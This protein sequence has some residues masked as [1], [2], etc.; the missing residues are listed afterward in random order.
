MLQRI[1][2]RHRSERTSVLGSL[3][4]KGSDKMQW[5][6]LTWL[7]ICTRYFYHHCPQKGWLDSLKWIF[8][9]PITWFYH[10][11]KLLKMISSKFFV[12]GIEFCIW[13]KIYF[14]LEKKNQFLNRKFLVAFPQ[15]REVIAS[16]LWQY[17]SRLLHTLQG[18][19]CC[20]Y[21]WRMRETMLESTPEHT[22]HYLR[23]QDSVHWNSIVATQIYWGF[24]S[25]D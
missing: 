8:K 10:W 19:R 21:S 22:H 9:Y 15:P 24:N 13:L 18:V 25:Q 2:R 3:A 1:V 4:V 5:K 6:M 23:S 11:G 20:S 14:I 12:T 17:S 7:R 16:W